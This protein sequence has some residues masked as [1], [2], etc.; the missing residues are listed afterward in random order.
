MDASMIWVLMT[1]LAT[2]AAVAW[3]V[4]WAAIAFVVNGSIIYYATLDLFDV[5]PSAQLTGA[6]LAIPGAV[7]ALRLVLRP[8]GASQLARN[9]SFYLFTAFAVIWY[10]RWL[11]DP[12]PPSGFGARALA[13][14]LVFAILPFIAG[15][16]IRKSELREAIWWLLGF[17]VVGVA[18]MLWYWLSGAATLSMNFSGRWEPIPYL[19]GGLI[20]IDL[21]VAC[22]SLFALFPMSRALVTMAGCIVASLVLAVDIRIGSRGPFLFLMACLVGYIAV[23][24]RR[25]G[26]RSA[27]L[28]AGGLAVAFV[29]ALRIASPIAEVAPPPAP[30]PVPTPAPTP[31]L[32]AVPAVTSPPSPTLEA[33]ATNAP[34]RV[35]QVEGYVSTQDRATKERLDTLEAA[36]NFIAEKPIFG[37]GGG[38]V[39]RDIDG[40]PWDY[41]HN[42][43]LDPFVETGVVGAVPYWT[44]F[45]LVA[46][47]MVKAFRRGLPTAATLLPILPLFA[48]A[49]MESLI[50]GHVAVSRHLWLFVGMACG[51]LLGHTDDVHRTVAAAGAEPRAATTR[52]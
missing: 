42:T 20:A 4:P 11:M 33:L 15:L 32:T 14:M 27:A 52:P 40:H 19:A 36:L 28:R 43:L 22:L 13:Y 23:V 3:F 37:W 45:V 34:P 41:A 7:A 39:G 50:S 2:V 44:L 10:A 5:A 51:L 49:F 1:V 18:V 30:T 35:A 16:S 26:V 31:A 46:L 17:G 6:I 47:S 48:F 38:L 9:P 12:P 21:G 25:A 8:G 24:V 29:L